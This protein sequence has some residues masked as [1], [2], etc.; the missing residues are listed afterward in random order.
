MSE[1]TFDCCSSFRKCSDT[2]ECV[3]KNNSLFDGCTYR[4]K[5]EAGVVFYGKNCNIIG[6]IRNGVILPS[7][8]ITKEKGKDHVKAEV[9]LTC[10]K[11]PFK[12]LRRSNALSYRL[13]EEHSKIIIDVFIMKDIPFK[14]SLDMFEEL[15]GDDVEVTG[16]CNSR[17]V[18]KIKETEYHILNFNSYLIHNW[19]AEKIN[20]AF[21]TKGIESRVELIGSYSGVKNEVSSIT[22]AYNPIA[23]SKTKNE[24]DTNKST[25]VQLTLFDLNEFAAPAYR[26]G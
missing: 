22:K 16:P 14:T 6:P 17:V 3:H 15:P 11:K 2:L 19:Y 9:Y 25:P 5:L 21:K 18:F 4:K 12:V 7:Q 26:R 10:Y 8:I 23:L 13:D 20:K 24:I 1:H